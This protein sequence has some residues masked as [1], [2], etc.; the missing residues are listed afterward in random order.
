MTDQII[1]SIE[2]DGANLACDVKVVFL[3]IVKYSLRQSVVQK[4]VINQFTEL[5]ATSLREVLSGY[6]H[7][8]AQPI[9]ELERGAIKIPTGDGLAV[10]FTINLIKIHL[11]FVKR[12]ALSIEQLN[13]SLACQGF[14]SNNWCNHCFSFY[15]RAGI[16]EG[17][18]IFFTDINGHKNVAG[19]PMNDAARIMSLADPGQVLLSESVFLNLEEFSE[20]QNLQA[21]FRRYPNVK[22]KHDVN[23]TIYQYL[24][25]APAVN[26][27]APSQIDPPQDAIPLANQQLRTY[28]DFD[29][30]AED[31]VDYFGQ[32][33]TVEILKRDTRGWVLSLLPSL[34]N[35]RAEGRVVRVLCA[36]S[37]EPKERQ[38]I[39]ILARSGCEVR[40][41]KDYP[42][43]PNELFLFDSR[44]DHWH[45]AVISLSL[46]DTS[47]HVYA[48]RYDPNIDRPAI[49]LFSQEFD[50][51]W[52]QG[53]VLNIQGTAMSFEKVDP[54]EIISRLKYGVRQYSPSSV[55]IE[56]RIVP[57]K[58]LLYLLSPLKAFKYKQVPRVMSFYGQANAEFFEPLAVKFTEDKSSI[59]TP[60]VIEEGY[61]KLVVLNGSHR[62]YHCRE[63]EIADEIGCIV[64]RGVLEALP[65]E[66]VAYENVRIA[67]SVYP[68]PRIKNFDYRK[69]R[70]IESAV[71]PP[72]DIWLES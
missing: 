9:E 11:D 35:A 26:I 39:G 30:A 46:E 29:H 57:I 31:L 66:P 15:I 36:E 71:H 62:T 20:G 59:I 14:R 2:L 50:K 45:R 34:L 28:N 24:G 67:S 19:K 61:D 52:Q 44:H 60:P 8:L 42:N 4:R 5:C 64:V 32:G 6:A 72:A 58:Q 37:L 1:P 10:V 38:C 16:S 51:W 33:E 56:Y 12:I 18:A 43:I 40:T 70:H 54:S 55:S 53:E 68:H 63:K 25:D 3:D 22:V 21:A 23:I 13:N 17:K 7:D 65:G 48:T 47:S 49:Q 69:Y 41:L 27:S